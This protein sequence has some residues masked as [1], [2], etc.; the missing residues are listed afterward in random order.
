MKT[1][2]ERKRAQRLRAKGANVTPEESDWLASYEATANASPFEAPAPPATPVES[3]LPP[4]TPVEAPPPA[5]AV[6]SAPTVIDMGG[7]FQPPSQ[8][9]PQVSN[10]PPVQSSPGASI[11]APAAP[12]AIDRGMTEEVARSAAGF[13]FVGMA[14]AWRHFGD[15]DT[16][17]PSNEQ[18]RLLAKV[19]ANYAIK[20]GWT[21]EL[22]DMIL[23]ITVLGT[24]NMQCAKAPLLSEKKAAPK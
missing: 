14:A 4:A 3:P 13:A 16:P 6:E 22:D 19:I 11:S 17:D 21:S 1:P 7:D 12:A 2:A 5:P 18:R 20:Y 8:P 24:Y 15:R 10:A 9:A 23:L